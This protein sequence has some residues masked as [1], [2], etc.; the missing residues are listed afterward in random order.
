MVTI[1]LLECISS[2]LFMPAV[3]CFSVGDVVEC[4]LGAAVVI[5]RGYII[6]SFV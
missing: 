3:L 2:F 1:V 5:M 4:G 6:G